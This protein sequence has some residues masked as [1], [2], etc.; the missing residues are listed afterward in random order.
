MVGRTALVTGST[1]GIGLGVARALAARGASVVVNG[2]GDAATI[3]GI[4]SELGTLAAAATHASGASAPPPRAMFAD[5]DLSDKRALTD[6]MARVRGDLGRLDILVNNAGIQHVANVD[7]FPPDA[8]ERVIAVSALR[9]RGD[10]DDDGGGRRVRVPACVLV[11]VRLSVRAG[12]CACVL[13]ELLSRA[14]ADCTP[15]ACLVG[16]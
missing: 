16:M 1:S 15:T 10:G 14:C 6:M 12:T 2:F 4:V 5:A 8:W 3:A 7:V 9:A 13:G 11:F